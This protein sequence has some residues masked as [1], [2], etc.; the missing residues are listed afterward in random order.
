LLT[1]DGSG[2]YISGAIMFEETPYQST[3]D[4]K[5]KP[6]FDCP[7]DQNIM[8]GIKFDKVCIPFLSILDSPWCCSQQDSSSILML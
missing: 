8:P 7:K 5:S 1:T 4:G 6:F 2:E 3:T